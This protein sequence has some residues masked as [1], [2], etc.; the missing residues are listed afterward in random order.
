MGDSNSFNSGF[1]P[2]IFLVSTVFISSTTVFSSFHC[3]FSSWYVMEEDEEIQQLFNALNLSTSHVGISSSTQQ[4][5]TDDS[6]RR[7]IYGKVHTLDK[8]IRFKALQNMLLS[9]WARY[10]V[11]AISYIEEKVFMAEF[12]SEDNLHQVIEDGPWNYGLDFII[13]EPIIPDLPF[14]CYTFQKLSI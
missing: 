7:S 8:V 14:S 1:L 3:L 12:N 13:F 5:N 2:V 10:G 6:W 9:I 11:I 4:L